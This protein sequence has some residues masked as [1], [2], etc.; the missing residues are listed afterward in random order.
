MAVSEKYL[1]IVTTCPDMPAAEKIADVLVE[2]SLAACVQIIPGIKS[3]F[4]WQGQVDYAAESLL[5]VKTV[6]E[7]YPEIENLINSIHG[8]D[9]PEIIAVPVSAGSRDYLAW[10]DDNTKAL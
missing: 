7:N 4:R 9:V 1:M 2:K 5:L 6:A 8:Y 10:I 3:V